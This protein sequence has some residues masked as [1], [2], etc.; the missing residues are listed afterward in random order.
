MNAEQRCIVYATPG[1]DV[2]PFARAV[3]RARGPWK[4]VVVPPLV[5]DAAVRA[6]QPEAVVV[7]S[8]QPRAASLLRG[9]R[10]RHGDRRLVVDDRDLDILT[11]LLRAA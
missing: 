5:L 8:D 3:A 2:R 4:P 9:A 1:H 6:L 10:K 11:K 7:A